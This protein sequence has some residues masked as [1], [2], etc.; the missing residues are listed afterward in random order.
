MTIMVQIIYKYIQLKINRY[1]NI[2]TYNGSTSNKQQ[3]IQLRLC[4]ISLITYKISLFP[5]TNGKI[6]EKIS[7][8]NSTKNKPIKLLDIELPQIVQNK[9]YN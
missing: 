3:M 4:D 5:L 1:D 2:V 8:S 6:F 9:S 7:K